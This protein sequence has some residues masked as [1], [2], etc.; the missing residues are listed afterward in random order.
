[1]AT[2][3]KTATT[4]AKETKEKAVKP[5]TKKAT[6]K[7]TKPAKEVPA[8]PKEVVKEVELTP[9]EEYAQTVVPEGYEVNMYNLAKGLKA[10]YLKGNSKKLTAKKCRALGISLVLLKAWEND[11][12]TLLSKC[13]TYIREKHG[14]SVEA[15]TKLRAELTEFVLKLFNRH[16]IKDTEGYYQF[17]ENDIENVISAAEIW[18]KAGQKI[19]GVEMPLEYRIA[20]NNKDNFT[21][22][23]ERLFM[24]KILGKAVL[25]NERRD[26]L[27]QLR[28]ISA[29]A[30]EPKKAIEANKAKIA[31]FEEIIPTIKDK[32]TVKNFYEIIKKCEKANEELEKQLDEIAKRVEEFARKLPQ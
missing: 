32:A 8:K 7:A 1:M 12:T 3:K 9:E 26:A 5:T 20:I 28:E 14:G 30:R 21:V 11:V 23:I 16:F 13:E 24:F 29:E 31:L 22:Q 18:Q 17:N 25:S 10:E 27:E 2:T 19:E 4:V 6:T 15:A